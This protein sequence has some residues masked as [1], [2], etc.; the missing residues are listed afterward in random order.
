MSEEVLDYKD[1]MA[2]TGL[3]KTRVFEL[4]DQGEFEGY[5]SGRRKLFFASSV[6]A[7]IERNRIG[8]RQTPVPAPPFPRPRRRQSSAHEGRV[9]KYL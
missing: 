6:D 8:V 4:L 9:F 2:R 3:G 7:Y 1:V 5:Q